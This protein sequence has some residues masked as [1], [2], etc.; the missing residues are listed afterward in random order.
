MKPIAPRISLAV[1]VAAAALVACDSTAPIACT[2]EFVYGIQVQVQ[3]SITGLPVE[4]GLGGSVQ[5]GAFSE[6]M[7]VLGN[8]LLGAGER[9][10]TYAVQV[11][12][13]SYDEWN[14][15][16]VVVTADECHVIP[17]SLVARL[18]PS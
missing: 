11:T 2:A 13:P 6:Q 17:V 12:A 10:G 8:L 16:D 18:R 14:T 1:A 5:D 15:S 4:T 3:D 9:A 7:T